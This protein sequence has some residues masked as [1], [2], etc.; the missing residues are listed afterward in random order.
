MYKSFFTT[1]EMTEPP[2]K[3][4]RTIITD[5]VDTHISNL[6]HQP[7]VVTI[8]NPTSASTPAELDIQSPF[9]FETEQPY[10]Q[11]IQQEHPVSSVPSAIQ[12]AVD[13]AR[14]FVGRPYVFGGNSPS[15]G[16]DCSGLLSY[17]FNQNGI[18]L[19]RSTYEIF[20]SGT[21]VK[22]EDAQVG[23]IICTPG[24][25]RSGRHVKVISKI[26]EDGIS[27]IEAKGKKWGITES[28]LEKTDNIITI[29]RLSEG[30]PYKLSSNTRPS[31]AFSSKTDFINSML[32]SYKKALLDNGMDPNYAYTLTSS[33][34]IESGWGTKV[35]G[36]FN[37]GGV[38][39]TT[40]K[41]TVAS[42][43]DYVPGRG[44]IRHNQTFRDFSSLDDYCNYMVKWLK[45]SDRYGNAFKLYSADQPTGLWR[46]VLEAG[47]GGGSQE[48]IN[49][50]M[51][52]FRQVYNDISKHS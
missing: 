45:S 4:R 3:K 18:D 22:L 29:R 17:V 7:M 42:T 33:A 51:I 36:K 52:T 32:S 34:A 40:G 20:K 14:T 39:S 37:Y 46:Y 25:G 6:Y 27:V 8:D 15:K 41:G 23:D 28:R 50:Y 19:G 43:I 10:V 49:K 12:G 35:S 31:G 1:Y 47:Y 11:G 2:P 16:F 24:S 30:S 48:N 9:V 13:L 26:D 21:E 5:S 44:N 38:K